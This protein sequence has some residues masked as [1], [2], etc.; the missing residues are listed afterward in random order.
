MLRDVAGTSGGPWPVNSLPS[1]A[2]V[3]AVGAHPD[4]LEILWGYAR[5]LRAERRDGRDGYRDGR[6]SG[7]HDDSPR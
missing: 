3:L 5:M 4:D 2:R 6:R 7:S 1:P